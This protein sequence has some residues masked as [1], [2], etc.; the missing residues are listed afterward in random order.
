MTLRKKFFGDRAFYKKVLAVS[1][2]IMVHNGITNLVGMLDNVMVGTLGTEAMSG[3]SIANQLL[4]VFSMVIFGAGAA[5]GIFP[6]T[7]TIGRIPRIP[8][9]P[10][11]R[12]S[13]PPT[14]SAS[15]L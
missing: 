3:V 11:A 14:N 7:A 13:N 10:S 8:P 12:R 2:P 1:V 5:G 15:L 6:L 4:F 9:T